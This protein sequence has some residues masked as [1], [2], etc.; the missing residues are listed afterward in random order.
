MRR[1]VLLCGLLVL[2]SAPR[3]WAVDPTRQI[4]QYGHTVWRIQD[5]SFNAAPIVITQTRDGYLWIGTDNGLLRFDGVRF[6]SWTPPAGKQLP[7]PLV[8][9]LLGAR[10]GSLWIGTSA[11]LSH[12]V[13]QDLVNYPEGGQFAGLLEDRD[14]SVWAVRSGIWTSPT[15][16]LC[17]IVDAALHCFGKADG[18]PIGTASSLADDGRGGLWI[19]GAPELVHGK[20][21]SFMRYKPPGLA[22]TRGLGIISGLAVAAEDTVWASVDNVGVGLQQFARGVWTPFITPELDGRMLTVS[23]LL[24]DRA[25]TLWVATYEGLYRIR[26]TTVDRF[27][28][29]D[30]LSS[31][32]VIRMFEDR[33][34]NLWVST[35]EGLDC[36][37]DLR[38]STFTAREGVP[39]GEVNS[40][41]TSRDGRLWISAL[42][43]L[44]VL[45]PGQ[46]RVSTVRK[47]ADLPGANVATVFEDHA[48][49][50][51]VGLDRTLSIYEH[52]RF[53]PVTRRDGG[54]AGL[55]V[56]MAEDVDQNLW[57]EA[58]GTP[59]T[60]LRIRGRAV[61]EEFPAPQMPAARKVAADPT[62]GIWLGLVTGDLA[63]Y[64]SGHLEIIP[65][66]R[67]VDSHVRYLAV[68]PDGSVLGAAAF[69][70]IGWK[71]GRS[72]TL[73]VGNGLPCNGVNAFV[74]DTRGALWLFM[75]CGLVE[76][77]KQD[78]HR[79][80]ENPAAVLRTR[81]LDAADGVR[82]G[83]AAFQG[84]ARTPDGRLWFANT[85][86]LQM[87]DPAQMDGNARAHP[88]I[89]EG[90]VADR[91]TYAPG[92]DLRIPPLVRD[93]QIA[94]TAM[95]F[96][97]P[98]RV[99]FRYQLEG[100]DTE[101][102]DPGTRRQAFY[103]DLRPG[104]YRFRVKASNN[105]GVWN[106]EGATL[107]FTILPAWYQ[108]GWFKISSASFGLVAAWVL[109]RLR[110]H[111]LAAQFNRGLDARVSER[112]RIAR[113]LHDTLLQSVHAL[114]IH[115]QAATNL[116]PARPDEAKR[117]LDTVI[118]RTSRAIAEG[119]D[120]VQDLRSSMGARNE[121]AEAISV[122][123]Q[124]LLTGD[125]LA[126]TV[127]R[128][129][130]EGTPRPLRPVL[131]DDVY[132]IAA[133]AVRNAVRHAEARVIQVDIRYDDRQLRLC[134]RD[135]GKGIDPDIVDCEP[136]AGHW[137][138]PGMR[139]RAALIG[140]Q[141]EVR[142]RLGSGTEV[143]LGIPA[144]RVYATSRDRRR[145]W[146]SG[147]KKGADS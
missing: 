80:W 59:R 63:R 70:L 55:I 114:L 40:V 26:G 86:N 103:S 113:E 82:P 64:R 73:T 51:W 101:W 111:Q 89:V 95:A 15:G 44:D 23:Q 83:F 87:I 32:A 88:V 34:G 56:G 22:V 137:G 6:V 54:P 31:D 35:R 143:N 5:G 60:L 21:G 74:E 85:Y 104:R 145:R 99:R 71:N 10:D 68:M 47:G 78:V 98:Q 100:R 13:N 144:A 94:Y 65:V 29:I 122:L 131:R 4:S 105:D 138:L 42:S 46:N 16:P 116:L 45:E 7:S 30:G 147:W 96:G 58:S 84:A 38:V 77:S 2:L 129:H 75:D 27:R 118:E 110:L 9:A 142:S 115:T 136:L 67:H 12:L 69:G 106:D 66:E 108:T 62:G 107:D 61:Q 134:V 48:G 57:T 141:L 124:E 79:W 53:T 117:R 140:G 11:G 25:R 146:F 37:R 93:L 50:L 41:F 39:N 120:A 119:R 123:G 24:V 19:G 109:Y 97:A 128:V 43:E 28:R 121:L 81:V 72:Q 92:H 17:H 20:P 133:E 1:L 102:Q 76:L 112:T 18:P 132:R 8:Y 126:T 135:D 127:L 90:I 125:S 52:G 36:F 33:D 14:G 130:V 91:T 139:E 3:V 49:R